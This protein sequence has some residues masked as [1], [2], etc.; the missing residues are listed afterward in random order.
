MAAKGPELDAP[1]LPDRPGA[2]DWQ[3]ILVI[4]WITSMV[5]GLGVSQVFAFVPLYLREM[6]VA[7][8]D[9]LRFVGIF[10]SLIFIVGAPLV[11]LWG[12]WADKYSR[13]AVV[14]RSALVEAVVFAGVALSQE[15]WQV[16]LSMLLV[17]FQLGNTGVMLAAIRDVVP[18]HRLGALIAVFG[19]S[20]PVGFAVGPILGG[21][22]VDGLGLP[23]AAIFWVSAALSV[24]TAL[25][26][27]F[28]AREVRPEVVPE[29]RVLDLAFG[30]VRGV[31]SDAAVRRI[32]AIFGIAFLA[33]QMS[34]PYIPVLA[35]QVNQNPAGVASAI[36][37]VAGTAALVGALVSP[38][39]GWIGDRIGFRPVL[40][41]ALVG[42]GLAS[43]V[44]PIVGTIPVLALAAASLAACTAAISAMVFGLLAIEVPAE[45][46]SA[47]LN[48]VY[49]PLYVAGIVGPT[50]GAIVVS[51]GLWA[52]FWVG[53]AIYGV[54]AATVALSRAR[55]SAVGALVE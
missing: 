51:A 23:L 55:T 27:A 13:K 50:L 45:R 41:A 46:R 12:V 32:F 39:G 52:P 14:A 9:R 11:P 40:V 7:E 22:I 3:R 17:G 33:A 8:P 30:A 38:I 36:A 20:G 18:L 37:L 49:L 24:G 29:G 28:G 16:A 42:G 1:D 47:T 26:V 54:G 6:G 15:P 10:G 35:E 44:M 31:L 48:L 4:F 2:A 53:A 5:E 19:V 21:L 43:L 34:R 25:L